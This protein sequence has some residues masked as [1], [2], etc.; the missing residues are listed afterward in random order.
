[1]KIIKETI[2]LRCI[3]EYREHQ[4]YNKHVY[5]FSNNSGGELFLANSIK[6]YD[7]NEPIKV[8]AIINDDNTFRLVGLAKYPINI[9]Q[10]FYKM[11]YNQ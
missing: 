7:V 8:D 10:D 6:I 5:R 9:H 2:E 1:M 4:Q 11:F 3:Y